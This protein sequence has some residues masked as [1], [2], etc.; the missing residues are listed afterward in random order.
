[1][2]ASTQQ[3][4][5]QR[6]SQTS[7][8]AVVVWNLLFNHRFQRFPEPHS[9]HGFLPVFLLTLMAVMTQS[10]S[11][12]SSEGLPELVPVS[13]FGHKLLFD[14]RAN[15]KVPQS[16]APSLKA[17]KLSNFKEM[18]SP[19]QRQGS[20]RREPAGKGG[21]EEIWSFGNTR[22][23]PIPPNTTFLQQPPPAA[24]PGSSSPGAGLCCLTLGWKWAPGL[25]LS[26]LSW[27]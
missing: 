22:S 4:S 19:N 2:I 1:M 3:S 25:S 27:L 24:L 21:L 13:P 6:A 23:S 12:D 7:P 16:T 18:W 20:V 10:Q 9:V 26:S 8:R 15:P 5:E 17:T 11:C 14:I